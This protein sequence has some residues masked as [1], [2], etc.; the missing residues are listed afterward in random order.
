MESLVACT[1]QRVHTAK[2]AVQKVVYG[3]IQGY[4]SVAH[5][6]FAVVHT[7][8]KVELWNIEQL[9]ITKGEVSDDTRKPSANSAGS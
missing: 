6:V 7:T 9:T 5:Q 1:T 2:G 3:K 8:T 4:V